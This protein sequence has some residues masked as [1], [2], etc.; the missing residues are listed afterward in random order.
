MAQAK[1]VHKIRAGQVSC[2]LWE[3]EMTL[4]GGRKIKALKA[5]LERRYKD[6]DGT[7]KSSGSFGRNEIPLALWCL[8]KAFD[9]IIEE[10]NNRTDENSIEEETIA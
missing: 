2:A 7:W 1:P 3:N 6:S 8:Q 10:G 9:H 4:S 5:T